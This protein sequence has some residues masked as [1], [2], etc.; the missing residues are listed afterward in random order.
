MFGMVW[1]KFVTGNSH[2][3][4]YYHSMMVKESEPQTSAR[5]KKYHLIWVSATHR[6]VVIVSSSGTGSN[7]H[8]ISIGV[9][10]VWLENIY[11][12]ILGRNCQYLTGRQ[13]VNSI[14]FQTCHLH[15]GPVYVLQCIHPD[16]SC[17]LGVNKYQYKLGGRPFRTQLL[18][19]CN[20]RQFI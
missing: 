18:I 15:H 12:S 20:R 9:F 4:C 16:V 14:Q 7:F 3:E 13:E 6:V 2:G 11:E 17:Y 19:Y 1:C 5:S 8:R 10:L